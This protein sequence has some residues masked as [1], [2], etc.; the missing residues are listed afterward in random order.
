[1]VLKSMNLMVFL[2]LSVVILHFIVY[3]HYC[4]IAHSYLL[5]VYLPSL[6]HWLIMEWRGYLVFTCGI[7]FSLASNFSL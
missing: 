5:L 1:M 4:P 2:T 6:N 7:L 3:L